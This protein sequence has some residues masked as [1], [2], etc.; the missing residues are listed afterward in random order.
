M[1][2]LNLTVALFNA[3]VTTYLSVKSGSV[4]MAVISATSIM[5]AAV[6]LFTV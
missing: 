2:D 5:W 4:R 6:M 3:G 1:E